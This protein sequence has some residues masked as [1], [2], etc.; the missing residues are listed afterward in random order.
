MDSRSTPLRGP[1]GLALALAGVFVLSLAAFASDAVASE[2]PPLVARIPPGRD[3]TLYESPTG[4]LSNGAGSSILAGR[5]A[6][7][8]NSIRRGLLWFD[9]AGALPAGATVTEVV[10]RLTLT[11]SNA[12][13]TDVGL[14]RVAADWGEGASNAD[15][16]P[17]SGAPAQAGDATWRHR[18]FSGTLW[19]SIGGDFAAAA[20][21]SAAVDAPGDSW[22]GSTP[23]LVADVQGWLD[24]P[25]QNFGWLVRGLETAS[26]T[27]KRFD[28]RESPTPETRPELSIRYTLATPAVAATWGRVKAGYR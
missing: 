27:A 4:A 1:L 13:A 18:F 5:T 26:G 9:V 14:H 19:S 22:W 8:S 28:T 10:L 16:G 3:N 21:A 23:A 17:G 2:E 15:A 11:A 25:A 12:G 7:A 6:Q 20:S 24:A